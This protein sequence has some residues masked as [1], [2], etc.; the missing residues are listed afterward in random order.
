ML[1]EE[2][3]VLERENNDDYPLFSWNQKRGEFSMG[4]SVEFKNS[5]K[6]QLSEPISPNFEWVDYHSLPKPVI[7]KQVANVLAPLDIYGIQLI[8]AEVSNPKDPFLEAK[9]YYFLHVWNRISCLD[10][11]NQN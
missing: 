2:Y 6:L 7:S 5:I 11:K 1:Q 9:H 10:K 3:Y 4:K 8:P